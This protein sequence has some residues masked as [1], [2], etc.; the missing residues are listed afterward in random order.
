MVE[1]IKKKKWKTRLEKEARAAI[2]KPEGYV[3]GA[4][5]TYKPEYCLLLI[6]H[7]AQG[8]SF[9]SFAAKVDCEERTLF[10]WAKQNPDFLAAKNLGWP[11]ARLFWEKLGV[12]GAAG[13]IRG[14][15][16]AAWIF[17]MKN[18]FRNEWRDRQEVEHQ[19]KPQIIERPSGEQIL[20]TS[21]QG[22]LEGEIEN[23]DKNNS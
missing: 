14:F 17:N 12:M 1:I 15:N 5:T 7:L 23:D 6:E 22:L 10:N 18:R 9:E 8:L 21:T 4:P 20:L 16:P 3:F 13:K 11:K 19:V 2:P